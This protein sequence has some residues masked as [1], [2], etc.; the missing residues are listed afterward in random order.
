MSEFIYPVGNVSISQGFTAGMHNGIDFEVPVGTPVG[1][2]TD[3]TVT[4]ENNEPGG[5]G[6]VIFLTAPNGWSTRYGHLSQFKIQQG[7]SVKQG[8]IIALSGGAHNA[9]GAGNSSGPHL[10]FEI[11]DASGTPIDPATLLSGTTGPVKDA[12]GPPTSDI[13]AIG[14]F[15]HFLLDAQTWIRFGEIVAGFI[16][17]YLSYSIIRKDI[18]SIGQLGRLVNGTL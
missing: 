18:S 9:E 13:S 5:Y 3:G 12:K 16:L 4:Y 8:Q 7:D 14:N 11:R 10:H 2:S 15:F 17:L 1:A 6:N